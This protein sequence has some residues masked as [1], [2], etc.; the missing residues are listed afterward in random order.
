MAW[1]RRCDNGC[2]SWPDHPLYETCPRCD[3]HTKRF[4]NL[5]PLDHDEAQ[6]IYLHIAF[7][8]YYEE[9]C[10]TLGVPVEGPLVGPDGITALAQK[11]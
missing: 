11:A 5:T 7:E 9:R 1:G 8:A 3:E 10:A 6:S 4:S 2:E